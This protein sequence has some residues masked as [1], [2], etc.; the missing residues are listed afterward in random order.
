MKIKPSTAFFTIGLMLAGAA[1][2][3]AGFA[4]EVD[5]DTSHP[6]VYVKDSVITTKIK[7]KLAEEKISSLIHI[8]VDTDNKGAV[9]L[10]GN[11]RSQAEI[12]KAISLAQ[13]TDGATSVKS[14]LKITKE[15]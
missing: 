13:K 6:Q 14:D 12:D 1:T 4:A 3:L 7:A 10:S 15:N 5:T 11:V 2:P 9:L 8:Q